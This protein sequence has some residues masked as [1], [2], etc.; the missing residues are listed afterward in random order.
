M[1]LPVCIRCGKTYPSTGAPFRCECGGIF[2]YA[3]FPGY[4]PDVLTENNHGLWKYRSS[5]GKDL[6][7]VTLGEGNTPLVETT[8]QSQ[9][10]WLKLE[11]LNP[12]GS[13]KDRGSA[14]LTSFLVSRGVNSAIED[15]SGNAGASFAAYA[16]RAGIQAKVY[17]P[18]SASGPKRAQ[19]EAYGADIK[20]IPGP[21]SEA[22]K[23]VLRQAERGTVYA[24]HAFMPFGLTGIATIAYEIA[25]QMGGKAPGTL[26][27]PVGHGGLLYGLMRGFAALKKACVVNKEPYYVGVQAAGCAPVF[28]AYQNQEMTLREPIQS[29]TIAE[30]VRVSSPAR[31]EAILAKIRNGG[32]EITAIDDVRLKQAYFDIAQKGFYIEPTSALCWAALPEVLAK[33]SGPVVLILTGSGYKTRL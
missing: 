7:A 3:E 6:P 4:S 23:A 9:S 28:A 16:A 20:L 32:G 33:N 2:D 18:E 24:S 12:S 13:Y 1:I 14:V 5:L 26:V 21:R 25:E 27:A 8:Y 19:I 22:A 17:I 11:Y 30:G 31:G 10:V 15:S 29:D